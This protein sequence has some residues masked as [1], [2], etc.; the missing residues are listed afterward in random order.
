MSVLAAYGWP[1]NIR[2]L[3][4]VLYG[5]L[6]R[7]RC[8]HELLVSDLSTRLLRPAR[9]T[10]SPGAPA[11]FDRQAIALELDRGTFNLR[12]TLEALEREAL[13][14]A[15]ERSQGNAA[16]AAALLGE[17]GR[18]SAQDPGA[19]VRAMVRRLGLSRPGAGQ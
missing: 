8:G 2:E 5:A 4:N 18:G 6:V 10:A 17:V 12:A 16:A 14:L 3:R 13:R 1:G 7:K 15:L 19:T 11:V 9:A